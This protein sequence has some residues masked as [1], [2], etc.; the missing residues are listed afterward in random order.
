MTGDAELLRTYAANRSEA[1][2]AELVAAENDRTGAI[3]R[4]HSAVRVWQAANAPP[5]GTEARCRLACL[6]E[7]DG[8][9]AFAIMELNAAARVFKHTG[10]K[11]HLKKCQDLRERLNRD[12]ARPA[13]KRNATTPRSRSKL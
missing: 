3:A 11:D 6:L 9:I 1:A 4:L 7:E 5:A 13:R 12:L 8:D 2:F 10:A